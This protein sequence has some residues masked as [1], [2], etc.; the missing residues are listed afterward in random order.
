M[1]VAPTFEFVKKVM[2]DE[3]GKL[4]KT[5]DIQWLIIENMK[6]SIDSGAAKGKAKAEYFEPMSHLRRAVGSGTFPNELVIM[7]KELNAAKAP[8]CHDFFTQHGGG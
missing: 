3:S 7:T 1:E 8:V 4:G 6:Y 2:G 5:L